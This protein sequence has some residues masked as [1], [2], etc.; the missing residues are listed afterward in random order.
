MYS[1]DLG[2]GRTGMVS[3]RVLTFSLFSFLSARL[4]SLLLDATRFDV[5]LVQPGGAPAAVV[6]MEEERWMK[7]WGGR[8]WEEGK[9]YEAPAMLL[10]SGGGWS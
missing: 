7:E 4:C 9:R 10:I 8:R 6:A 5:S 1:M 3:L 2:G